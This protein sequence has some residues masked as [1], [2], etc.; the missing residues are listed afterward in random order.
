M[1]KT[2]QNQAQAGNQARRRPYLL[3]KTLVYTKTGCLIAF[4]VVVSQNH[5]FYNEKQPKDHAA[6]KFYPQPPPRGPD[7]Y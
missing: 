5:W 1:Y 2:Q 7:L 4:T 3:A 6:L